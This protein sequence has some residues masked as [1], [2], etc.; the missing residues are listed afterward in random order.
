MR[1]DF[2]NKLSFKRDLKRE[3]NELEVHRPV[4]YD[5]WQWTWHRLL[6]SASAAP[7]HGHIEAHS[8]HSLLFNFRIREN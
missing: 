5:H 6:L 2:L 3:M 8:Y 7:E 1:N 4:H